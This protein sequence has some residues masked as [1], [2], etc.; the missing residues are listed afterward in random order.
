MIDFYNRNL[1]FSFKIIF[2][3]LTNRQ[4]GAMVARLTPDQKVASSNSVVVNPI[5]NNYL[6]IEFNHFKI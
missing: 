1:I 3:L 5:N 4:R 6:I 2:K